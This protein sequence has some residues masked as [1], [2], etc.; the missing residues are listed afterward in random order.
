MSR[1]IVNYFKFSSV[2][3]FSICTS[4]VSLFLASLCL[5]IYGAAFERIFKRGCLGAITR[6]C[7]ITLKLYRCP[8]SV[9]CFVLLNCNS[10]L[11][12]EHYVYLHVLGYHFCTSKLVFICSG[13]QQLSCYEPP[14]FT[15]LYKESC[16]STNST[17]DNQEACSEVILLQDPTKKCP[18]VSFHREG[19]IHYVNILIVSPPRSCIMEE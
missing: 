19:Q 18:R 4:A 12:S 10:S 7:T 2:S 6:Q 14:I 8:L 16:Y 9:F 3:P 11:S 15:F 5:S 1:G 17:K 13:E